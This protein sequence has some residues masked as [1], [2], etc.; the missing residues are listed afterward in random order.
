[1]GHRVDE[2][3]CGGDRKHD[4]AGIAGPAGDLGFLVV[5]DAD[6]RGQA[7]GR[8]VSQQAILI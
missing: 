7:Q 6:I 4:R 5:R 1:M 8:Q 3:A 2:V